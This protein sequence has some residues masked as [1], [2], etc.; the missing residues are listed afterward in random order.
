VG[1]ADSYHFG[2]S[3]Q[4]QQSEKQAE[5]RFADR[6]NACLRRPLFNSKVANA[7]LARAISFYRKGQL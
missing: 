4:E 1:K 2:S 7:K 6:E 3:E 5:R